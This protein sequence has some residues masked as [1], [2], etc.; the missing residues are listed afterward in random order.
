M[1]T[2]VVNGLAY[3]PTAPITPTGSPFAWTNPES[4]RV[5]VMLSGGTLS[6]IQLASPTDGQ[7]GPGWRIRLTYL[8]APTMAYT[9]G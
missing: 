2:V 3:G 9:P 1:E 6:L 7:L 4:V 5:V 8:L